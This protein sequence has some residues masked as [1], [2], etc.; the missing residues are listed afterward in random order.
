MSADRALSCRADGG[1][2]ARRLSRP[3]QS[4]PR[5][6]LLE[7]E[8]G[9]PVLSR[10]LQG[11][12]QT[13]A[14]GR[15]GCS[16][17]SPHRLIASPSPHPRLTLASPSPHPRLTLASPSPPHGRCSLL[18]MTDHPRPPDRLRRA[19]SRRRC[20]EPSTCQSTA[21]SPRLAPSCSPRPPLTTRASTRASTSQSRP[22]SPSPIG[23]RWAAA[24]LPLPPPHTLPQL[25]PSPQHPPSTHSLPFHSTPHS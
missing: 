12:P 15:G 23:C 17:S 21:V 25:P 6:L 10:D 4:Q 18:I 9:P 8:R 24:L 20:S 1:G 13:S 3:L 19:S 22:T 5:P 7:G 2:L 11:S 14:T 16:P